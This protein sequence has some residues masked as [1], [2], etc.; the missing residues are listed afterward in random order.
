MDRQ[1][2]GLKLTLDALKRPLRLDNF[3]D[4]LVLQKAI[5]LAQA[6]GVQLGY[7]F[8]WYLKG[9]YSPGLTRDAFAV[10]AELRQNLDDSQ[11]WN[12]DPA[13]A[14]RLSSLRKLFEGIPVEQLPSNL[15]LLASV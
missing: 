5:Y 12:L 14:Q 15:E 2:V 13:S 6:A 3:P 4:R 8:H 10:V 1:Q 9:P 7:Q 11:G